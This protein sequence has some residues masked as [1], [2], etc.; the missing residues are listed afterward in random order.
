MKLKYAVLFGL[1]ALAAAVVGYAATSANYSME[2]TGFT[3]AGN[4]AV[5]SPSYS[6]NVSMGSATIET[7][8]SPTY[9]NDEN[10]AVPEVM[11]V[12]TDSTTPMTATAAAS[13]HGCFIA[14]LR[15]R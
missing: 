9:A 12:A 5:A 11:I 10:V 2:E 3:V 8:T 4:T 13:D 7:G 6:M 1:L 15:A 14:S